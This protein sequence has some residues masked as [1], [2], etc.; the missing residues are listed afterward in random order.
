MFGKLLDWFANARKIAARVLN[1]A[2]NWP[3]NGVTCVRVFYTLEPGLADDPIFLTRLAWRFL[4]FD[5][6]ET[7]T[8]DELRAR[9]ILQDRHE[10]VKPAILPRSLTHGVRVYV[11][12]VR[13]PLRFFPRDYNVYDQN[14]GLL[15]CRLTERTW[16]L[17]ARD[18]QPDHVEDWQQNRIELVSQ[19]GEKVRA[20]RL[21]A[22]RELY[23]PGTCDQPGMALISFDDIPNKTAWLRELVDRLYQLKMRPPANDAEAAA[24]EAPMASEAGAVYHRRFRLP[25]AFTG[26][27]LVYACDLWYHRPYLQDGYMTDADRVVRAVAELGDEGGIEHLPPE[28]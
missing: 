20:V 10:L 16:K 18:L 25:R 3:F 13:V 8:R 6:D 9:E 22:N 24:A 15:H 14:Q 17:E 4:F 27:P 12:D 5:Q 11:Q 28:E 26:G 1:Y 23:Q 19:E 7:G 2:P 21:Q